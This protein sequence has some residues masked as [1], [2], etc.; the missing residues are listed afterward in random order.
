MVTRRQRQ[1]GGFGM[2]LEGGKCNR[3]WGGE[4]SIRDGCQSSGLRDKVDV[5]LFPSIL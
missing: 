3:T 1:V 4:R 2:Y 5:E